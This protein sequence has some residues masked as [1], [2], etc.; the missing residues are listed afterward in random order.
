[1]RTIQEKIAA[2]DWQIVTSEM[3][4]KGF[5]LVPQLLSNK[6]CEELI[7]DYDDPA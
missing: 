4:E 1:M 7:G 6:Y 3:N 5:A 2:I